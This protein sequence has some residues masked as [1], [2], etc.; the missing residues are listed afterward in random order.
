MH[1]RTA[2]LAPTRGDGCAA[3]GR[4]PTPR[5]AP[6]VG[7]PTGAMASGTRGSSSVPALKG[8]RYTSE[9]SP[10]E[11]WAH[12][13][14]L[15]TATAGDS[16]PRERGFLLHWGCLTAG[17][18]SPPQACYRVSTGQ[19]THRA[20]PVANTGYHTGAPA[21]GGCADHWDSGRRRRGARRHRPLGQPKGLRAA[22][23]DNARAARASSG[24]QTGVMPGRPGWRPPGRAAA[25]RPVGCRGQWS[26]PSQAS[27][28]SPAPGPTA[29][30]IHA[31]CPPRTR[32]SYRPR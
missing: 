4:V 26:D 12:L 14:I 18:T 27:H 22:S 24:H 28:R 9:A 1:S 25:C 29:A 19:A 11:R 20:W 32:S 7:E 30:R 15:P 5:R 17:L 23:S 3:G 13:D 16:R 2:T 31:G 6:D 8:G 21:S 10:G